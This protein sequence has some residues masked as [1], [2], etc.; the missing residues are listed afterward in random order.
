V[1]L[2]GCRCWANESVPS[3]IFPDP[4]H[5]AADFCVDSRLGGSMTGDITPGYN[6]LQAPPQIKG[7]PESPCGQ[8]EGFSSIF[9]SM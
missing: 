3:H 5:V 6:A 9:H 2:E 4:L 1:V 8:R 7:P